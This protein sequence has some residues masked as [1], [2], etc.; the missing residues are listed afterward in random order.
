[1]KAVQFS[2]RMH[3]V[4]AEFAGSTGWQWRF[5]KRHGIR[6]LSLQGEKLSANKEAAA[7]LTQSFCTFVEEENLSL[8]Q[9][10]NCQV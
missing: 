10:F 5:C 2:K 9:I 7:D 8:D 4:N 3:G 1:M 6:S